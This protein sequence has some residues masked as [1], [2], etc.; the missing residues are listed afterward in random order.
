MADAS[1]ILQ[2]GES[3][4]YTFTIKQDGAAFNLTGFTPTFY[5]HDDAEPAGVGNRIDG[6]AMTVTDASAGTA[7][8]QF[9]TTDTNI[10][11]TPTQAVGGAFPS[12]IT[13]QETDLAGTWAIKV[14]EDA[15]DSQVY[16]TAQERFVVRKNP[17]L[18]AESS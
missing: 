16:W 9:T 13:R 18:D 6:A 4:V 3:V 12:T 17:F 15:G 14:T 7:T 2:E 5:A 10:I 1:I 8:Y 11:E